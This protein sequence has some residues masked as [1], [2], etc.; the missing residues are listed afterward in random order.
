MVQLL[1]ATGSLPARALLL[2]LLALHIRSRT[3]TQ[4]PP[5]FTENTRMLFTSQIRFMRNADCS[6]NW[7]PIPFILI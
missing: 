2:T 3:Y 6:D 7:R 1:G 5:V 4:S